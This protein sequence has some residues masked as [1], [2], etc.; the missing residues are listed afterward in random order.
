MIWAES[1]R[2]F[3][4]GSMSPPEFLK[5][6]RFFRKVNASAQKLVNESNNWMT[7]LPL[8]GGG[9]LLKRAQGVALGFLPKF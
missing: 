4:E 2:L 5:S 6:H 3:Q 8:P 7:L 9:A 1:L